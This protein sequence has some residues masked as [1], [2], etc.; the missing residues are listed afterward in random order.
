ML[1]PTWP[2]RRVARHSFLCIRYGFPILMG[3]TLSA[4]GLNRFGELGNF[5]QKEEHNM[6]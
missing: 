4:N 5:I 2:L 6:S 3:C 1:A